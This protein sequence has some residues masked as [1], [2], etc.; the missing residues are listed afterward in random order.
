VETRGE[1][2]RGATIVD[3]LGVLGKPAN[4]RVCLAADGDRFRALLTSVLAG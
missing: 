2:T 1:L 4:T 3:L